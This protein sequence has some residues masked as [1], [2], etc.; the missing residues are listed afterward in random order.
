MYF[1]MKKGDAIATVAQPIA[2]SIDAVFGTDLQNC[3]GCK[4]MQ[5]NLNMGMS[6]ADSF[7][8]RFWPQKKEETK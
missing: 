8:D 3:S 6:L 4:K 2:R 7:F 5:H 1:A